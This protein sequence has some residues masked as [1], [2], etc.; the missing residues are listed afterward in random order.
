MFTILAVIFK[1]KRSGNHQ[2]VCNN[3]S[4]IRIAL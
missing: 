4:S 3:F 2:A 1:A